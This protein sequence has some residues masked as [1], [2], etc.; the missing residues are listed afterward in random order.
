MEFEKYVEGKIAQQ[1]PLFEN[2]H[3]LEW[4]NKF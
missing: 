1:P 2:D 4:K 3:F